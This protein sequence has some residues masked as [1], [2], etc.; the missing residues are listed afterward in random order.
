MPSEIIVALI[1]L[2]GVV[3]GAIPTYFFMRQKSMVEIEKIKAET[4]KL[5][6]EADLLSAQTGK[7]DMFLGTADTQS[8][9]SDEMTIYSLSQNPS[10]T[11]FEAKGVY[12]ENQDPSSVGKGSLSLKQGVLQIERINLTGSFSTYLDKYYYNNKEKTLI[13]QNLIATGTRKL[14]ISCQVKTNKGKGQLSFRILEVQSDG[15]YVEPGYIE[16]KNMGEIDNK[17]W[18]DIELLFKVSPTSNYKIGFHYFN[19][20]E[21]NVLLMKNLI[22]TERF[23][24]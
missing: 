1:G 21:P 8:A 14:R 16:T 10:S 7:Q 19:V 18:S 23:A 11:D 15:K 2:M 3:I 20:S 5:N 13:P 9:Q 22:I 6:I 17:D 12:W 24:D 4:K